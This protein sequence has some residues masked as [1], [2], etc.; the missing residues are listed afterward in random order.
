MVMDTNLWRT[1]AAETFSSAVTCHPLPTG[2]KTCWEGRSLATGAVWSHAVVSRLA[3]WN[4]R[5]RS[6][7]RITLESCS[8]RRLPCC[9]YATAVY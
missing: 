3:R 8:T 2:W 9:H 4:I 5:Y 1:S 6:L 7:Q